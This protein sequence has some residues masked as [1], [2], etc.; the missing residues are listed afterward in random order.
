MRLIKAVEKSPQFIDG[1]RLAGTDVKGL[2]IAPMQCVDA[3]GDHI[4]DIDEIPGLLPIALNNNILPAGITG[5][6]LGYYPAVSGSL[7]ARPINIGESQNS[8]LQPQQQVIHS[9]IAL[10]GIFGKAVKRNRISGVAFVQ[11][12]VQGVAINS[13]TGSKYYFTDLIFKRMAQYLQGTCDIVIR[14]KPGILLGAGHIDLGGKMIYKLGLF[15]GYY[16]FQLIILDIQLVEF[17]PA[18]DIIKPA[19]T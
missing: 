13:G 9:Y 6:E 12:Q 5:D 4:A 14:I 8:V 7:L 2:I 15:P 11:G 17:S 18:I 3:S 16:L 19:G 10:G 1:H